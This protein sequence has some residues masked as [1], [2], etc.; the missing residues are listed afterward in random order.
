MKAASVGT[1]EATAWGSGL[2]SAFVRLTLPSV[3]FTALLCGGCYDKVELN[4]LAV[5]D[6]MAIDITEDGKL[7]VSLQFV[8]PGEL[9]SPGG[10]GASTATRDAFYVIDAKGATL[11]EAFSLLQAKLPRRLFTTHVR[12]VV[13]GEEVARAG[14]GPLFDSLTR[15]RE[16]RLTMDVVLVKGRAVEL[17]RAAPRFERLPATAI[18]HL[19]NERI[20]PNRTVRQVAMSLV[21]EGVDLFLPLVGIAERVEP[22]HGA[23]AGAAS[24]P[25]TSPGEFEI[26]GIGIF[27][28]D[29]LVGFAPVE[30]ARGLAWIINQTATSTAT[31][32]WPPPGEPVKPVPAPRSGHAGASDNP[33]EPPGTGPASPGG[34]LNRPNQI[35]TILLRETTR[36]RAD[37]EDGEIV[38]RIRARAVDDLLT[39]QAGLDL[40]DPAVIPK[41]EAEIAKAAEER[42][43]SI[44]RLAQDEL[45]SDIFGFGALVRRSHPKLWREFRTNWREI[46]SKLRVEIEVVVQIRRVGLTNRPASMREDQLQR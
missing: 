21:A 46:F 24:A 20:V 17:L 28:E 2:R 13:L 12:V 22:V 41:L 42:M 40:N 18:A 25:A 33:N 36:I 1:P 26:M 15:M 35:S 37:V 19:L 34:G 45:Q 31:V 7:L 43:R 11:P 8:I 38:I 39:N 44:L 10:G 5:A 27:Q 6:L 29:R 30:A 9:G 14:I 16:L 3:I 4:Q 32:E 23:T